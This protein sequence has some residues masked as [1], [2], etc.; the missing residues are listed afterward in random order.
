MQVMAYKRLS[1]NDCRIVETQY[2]ASPAIQDVVCKHRETQSIASLQISACA[3]TSLLNQI[4][5]F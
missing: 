1:K 2:F 5:I 4:T 3:N